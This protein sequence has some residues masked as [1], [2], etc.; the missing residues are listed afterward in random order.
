MEHQTVH[1]ELSSDQMV[2]AVS[3]YIAG[4]V[5]WQSPCFSL[6]VCTCNTI[7]MD[8]MRSIGGAFL[9]S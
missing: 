5:V 2:V 8:L 4:I 1:N 7:V 9:P 6:V 3:R